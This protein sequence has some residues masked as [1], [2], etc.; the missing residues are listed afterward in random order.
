M[1][2]G[3]TSRAALSIG[4]TLAIAACHS[5]PP[6][7][8]VDAPAPAYPR[9]VWAEVPAGWHVG[10]ASPERYAFEVDETTAH[11]GRASGV[12]AQRG[13]GSESPGGGANQAIRADAYRGQ[14]VRL[15]A[16]VRARDATSALSWLR[17]DGVQDG[18]LVSFALSNAAGGP[19]VG[20]T[21]WQRVVHVVDVPQAA[22]A[23]SFGVLT[24]GGGRVWL[25]D[26]AL[27]VAPS[28][29]AS[30]NLLTSP[31]ALDLPDGP[32]E[33]R[34]RRAEWAALPRRLVNGGFEDGPTGRL[35]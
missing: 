13:G 31:R 5:S 9:G 29:E 23:I 16:Y 27:D 10:S 7:P 34:Q 33:R 21:D 24:R 19:I 4:S 1:R 18:E 30:T 14:R 32:V 15:T 3:R 22:E 11:G 8:Q 25:D 12:I 35:R 26:V 6:R 20:T 2:I 28:S 17:V